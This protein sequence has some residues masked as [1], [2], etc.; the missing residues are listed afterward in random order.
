MPDRFKSS[1]VLPL[2]TAIAVSAQLGCSKSEESGSRFTPIG[3]EREIRGTVADT[4]LTVCGPSPDK[5]GTCEGTLVVEPPGSGAAGRVPVEVT[6]DVVLK[7]GGQS[8]FLPQL[9]D[10]QVTVKYRASKEGPNVAT[11]VSAQ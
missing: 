11:S 2:L 6:R 5:P 9:R 1:I 3:E 10:S 4:K 8:V 7:K